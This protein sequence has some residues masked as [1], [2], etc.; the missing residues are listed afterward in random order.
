MYMGEGGGLMPILCRGVTKV[1]YGNVEQLPNTTASNILFTKWNPRKTEWV[2]Y[3]LPCGVTV[4]FV[5]W[6]H[7]KQ[8]SIPVGCVSSTAV[9]ISPATHAHS[10]AMHAPCHAHPLPHMPPT[11]H[12][13]PCHACSLPL[14]R[15]VIILV[16]GEGKAKAEAYWA[17]Q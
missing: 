11:M 12:T 13:H 16:L 15:T 4:T 3:P 9:A 17:D 5:Q 6:K 7:I 8:E 10:P 2:Q 14:L 1:S